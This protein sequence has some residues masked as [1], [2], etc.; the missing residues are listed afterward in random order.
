[1][2]GLD[3]MAIREGPYLLL[4]EVLGHS[5]LGAQPAQAANGDADELLELPALLQRPA[6]RGPCASLRDSRVTPA[7]ALLLLSHCSRAQRRSMRAAAAQER[8]PGRRRL[9]KEPLIRESWTRSA[10]WRCLSQ[11]AGRAG[12]QVCGSSPQTRGGGGKKLQRQK[13]TVMGAKSRKKPQH[14]GQKA[15][16]AGAK[17][18]GGGGKKPGQ[19]KPAATGEKTRAAKSRGGGG[20]KPRREKPAAAGA[21]N[22]QKAA[23]AGAKF[24]EA[25]GRKPRWR[26]QKATEAGAK[27]RGG[28]GIKPQ[29]PAAAGAKIHGGKKPRR[30]GQSSGNGVEGQN[31]LAFLECDVEGKVQRKT[32]KDVSWLDSV[33]LRTQ[34]LS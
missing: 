14:W 8:S 9:G 6:G 7:T 11:D 4:G 31:S 32:N 5:A 19:E 23:A 30:R 24:R 17:S 26:G 29:K 16:T 34:M 18:P 15:A 22:P 28:G 25:G 1:M 12:S 10:P 33:Q 20:K 13:A 27:S 2:R 21:K 3:Q